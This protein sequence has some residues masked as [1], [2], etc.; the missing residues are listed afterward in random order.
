MWVYILL[1]CIPLIYYSIHRRRNIEA[2]SFFAFFM[3]LLALFVGCSD[4]LGG[5]DRYIYADYFDSLADDRIA[6]LDLFHTQLWKGYSNEFGY[7]FLN[8][9]ISYF[10]SNRYIFIFLVT[11][12]I[13][14]LLYHTFSLYIDNKSYGLLVF[15]GLWFFFSFTY[16]RQV[17]GA[18]VAFCS[19]KY[20]YER[21][22]LPFAIIMLIAYSFHNSAFIFFPIYFL[23]IKKFTQRQILAVMFFCLLIGWSGLSIALYSSYDIISERANF[24]T[25]IQKTDARGAYLIEAILFLWLLL[26]GYKRIGQNKIEILMYNMSFV[27]CAILLFFIRSEN[28][29][30]LT[31]YYMGGLIITLTNLAT[32]K[33]GKKSK[34][35]FILLFISCILYVRIIVGWSFMLYPYKTFFTD[36]FRKN[37]PIYVF[38]EYDDNYAIDKFYR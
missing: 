36:G 4:M 21:R 24:D 37:D 12:L 18:T 28:G 25:Y 38:Y 23:P 16:I 20:I 6:G 30:R 5:Y 34:I 19:I 1:F 22:F 11:C 10:T 8:W 14:I 2:R 3:L 9:L 13:Y 29:G 17:I 15:M 31:W 32:S 33:Y 7:V 35:D 26:K 27:F